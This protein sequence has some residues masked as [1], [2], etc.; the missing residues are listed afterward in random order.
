[1]IQS[2]KLR[3]AA[4]ALAIAAV[5]LSAPSAFAFTTEN[6]SADQNA[7]SR[8]ADP[9]SQVKNG[10]SVFGPNGP[11]LHFGTSPGL[12]PYSSRLGG[13]NLNN[14]PPNPYAMP[15]GNGN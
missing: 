7:N 9:D 6:L 15:P 8:F 1:M 14:P 2:S 11:S 5:T 10:Q 3:L 13:S 4:A 12:S